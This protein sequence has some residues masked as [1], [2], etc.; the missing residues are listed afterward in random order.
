M[1]GGDIGATVGATGMGSRFV[2]ED[3]WGAHSEGDC[4]IDGSVIHFERFT[5]G[6]RTHSIQCEL[7]DLLRSFI[8]GYRSE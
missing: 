2:K 3:L 4:D 7:A 8:S 6:D 1:C 5:H